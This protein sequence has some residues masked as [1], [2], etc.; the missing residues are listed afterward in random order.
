MMKSR[1]LIGAQFLKIETSYLRETE[2]CIHSA[3]IVSV[4]FE[5]TR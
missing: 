1:K 5:L 2:S 4:Y 3:W